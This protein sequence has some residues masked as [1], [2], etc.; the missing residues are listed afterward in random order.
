VINFNNLSSFHRNGAANF[1]EI[2]KFEYSS[3]I[4][5]PE[6]YI[7]FLQWANGGAGMIGQNSFARFWRLEELLECNE[8]YGVAEYVPELFLLGSD[9]GVRLLRLTGERSGCQSSK[10]HL[11][12]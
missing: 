5:L 1:D 9:G 11:F 6:D 7:E 3:G 2:R 4:K 8:G 12:L 10:Y